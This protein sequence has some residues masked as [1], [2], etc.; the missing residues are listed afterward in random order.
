MKATRMMLVLLALVMVLGMLP[1]SAFATEE[2][3]AAVTAEKAVQTESAVT[4]GTVT[5]WQSYAGSTWLTYGDRCM[6]VTSQ[7]NPGTVFYADRKFENYEMELEM[8]LNSGP[9]FGVM[10]RAIGDEKGFFLVRPG[11]SG[12]HSLSHHITKDGNGWQSD[13]VS[14]EAGYPAYTTGTVMN[15][16]VRVENNQVSVWTKMTEDADYY[17]EFNNVAVPENL[18]GAGYVGIC[19]QYSDV[20][21]YSASIQDLDSDYTYTSDFA[22]VRNYDGKWG[23]NRGTGTPT[24]ENGILKPNIT[25]YQTL[26][27]Y[28]DVD[29]KNYVLETELAYFGNYAGVVFRGTNSNYAYYQLSGQGTANRSVKWFKNDSA[30]TV[31]TL[32]DGLEGSQ[33]NYGDRIRIRITINDNLLTVEEKVIGKD[34]DW[35]KTV[36]AYSLTEN[37]PELGIAGMIGLYSRTGADLTVYDLKI[38]DADTGYCYKAVEPVGQWVFESG[39]GS[40]V[41]ENGTIKPGIGSFSTFYKYSNINWENYVLETEFSYDAQYAGLVFRGYGDYNGYYNIT[42]ADTST[43]RTVNYWTLSS[44]AGTTLE[45]V[46]A[47]GSAYTYGAKIKL[48]V[49]VN[50]SILTIEE[51][52]DGVDTDWVKTVDGYSLTENAAHLGTAGSIGFYTRKGSNLTIYNLKVT[53]TDTGYCYKA[54]DP[55]GTWEVRRGEANITEQDG[56]MS[57]TATKNP[58]VYIYSNAMWDNYMLEA[59]YSVSAYYGA[60]ILRTNGTYNMMHRFGSGSYEYRGLYGYNSSGNAWNDTANRVPA[61]EGYTPYTYGDR[62]KVRYTVQNNLLTVQTLIVG[63]DTEWFTELEN[64]D[65]STYDNGALTGSGEIGFLTRTGATVNVYSFKITDTD[66]GFTYDML[67]EETVINT[68]SVTF[69]GNHVIDTSAPLTQTPDTMEIWFK[70]DAKVEQAL[71]S[72]AWNGYQPNEMYLTISDAG[73]LS[74]HEDNPDSKMGTNV[75]FRVHSAAG[76]NDGKWHKAVIRRYYDAASGL[77]KVDLSVFT[78]DK[79]VARSG[80][81]NVIGDTKLEQ[82]TEN[83]NR[84]VSNRIM[85]IGTKNDNRYVFTG[86]IGEI[87]MWDSALPDEQIASGR[88]A[89]DGTETGLLHCFIPENGTN[90]VDLVTSRT[91]NEVTADMAELWMQNYVIGDADWRIAVLPDIQH[92]TE[93]YE[94]QLRKYFAWI[95]D[96]AEK[97]NIKLVMSVGDMVNTCTPEQMH[98]VSEASSV[99]DGKVPFMPL[100]GNHDYPNYDRDFMLWNEYFPYAKYSQYDYFGGAFEEGR[101]DNYYYLINIHGED[102]LFMGLELCVRPVVAQWA[103]E[104][105]A[106]HPDHK[107][108]I[109][110]HDYLSVDSEIVPGGRS[111]SNGRFKN[112][113]MEATELYDCLISQHDNILLVISGHVH[114]YLTGRRTDVTESGHIVNSLG[115]DTAQIERWY[116]TAGMVDFLGFTDGSNTVQVNS[117]STERGQFFKSTDQFTI[118]LDWDKAYPGYT[119]PETV[120]DDT[121]AQKVAAAKSALYGGNANAYVAIAGSAT[122]IVTDKTYAAGAKLNVFGQSVSAW[123]AEGGNVY[124]HILA[125]GAAETVTLKGETNV[126][127]QTGAFASGELEVITPADI[128]NSRY[129]YL[130]HNWNATVSGAEQIG[131]TSTKAVGE[132]TVIY[133]NGEYRM[134]AVSESL[135]RNVALID[136]AGE[137]LRCDIALIEGD[138]FSS[139]TL[140]ITCQKEITVDGDLSDWNENILSTGRTMTG[141]GSTTHKNVTVYAYMADDGLYVAAVANHEKY[142]DN[143]D[144]WYDNTNLEFYLNG[145]SARYWLTANPACAHEDVQDAFKTQVNG[146]VYTTVAEGF[147][148]M[149]DLPVNAAGGEIKIGFAWKTP[150]DN[151]KYYNMTDGYDWW[152]LTR[153]HPSKI[154]EQYYVNASGVG[155]YSY[156]RDSDSVALDGDFS[157]FSAGAQENKLSIESQDG[158]VGFDVVAQYIPGYGVYVGVSAQSKTNPRPDATDT[159]HH[160]TNLEFY[161]GENR[162]YI[163][164]RGAAAGNGLYAKNVYWDQTY[165]ETAGL[166]YTTMEFFIPASSLGTVNNEDYLRMGFAFKPTGESVLLNGH[167]EATDYWHMYG[168]GPSDTANQFYVYKNGIH[169]QEQPDYVPYVAMVNG[170]GYDTVQ[171]A[172]DNANGGVVKLYANSDEEVV[173]LGDLYLDLNGYSLKKVIVSGTLYGMD[174]ATDD[175]VSSGA[176]IETVEGTYAAHY[177]NDDAKRYLAI[178]EGDGVSFHRFYMGITKVS[179]K[180]EAIGFG[181]KAEFYGDEAVQAQIESIGYTLWMTEGVEITRS[182]NSFKSTLTLRLKNYDVVNYGQTAVNAKVFVTLTDGT[183]I[184]SLAT[185]YSMRQMLEVIAQQFASYTTAQKK[186]VQAMCLAQETTHSWDIAPILNWTETVSLTTNYFTETTGGVYTLTTDS[187]AQHLVDDVM[188]DGVVA[189]YAN[190]SL[191]GT[192]S[193]TD[194]ESW[195]QARILVSADAQNEYFIALEKTD[196]G[197]YQIFT[198]SKANEESWNNWQLIDDVEQNGSRNSIDFEV[199][200]IGDALYFLIEDEVY[201]TSNSVSMTESTV[202]FTGYNVGTTTVEN[203]AL[204]VFED[205]AAAQ[206]YADSKLNRYGETFGVSNGTYWTTNG[207]DTTNDRGESPVLAITGG[208]P[209]YAYVNGVYGDQFTMET[210]INVQAVLNNDGYPKFGLLVNGESEMVKFFVDMTPGMTAT[211][212]GVVYQPTGGSDDWTNSKSVEVAGMSFAG[213]DTIKLKLVRDGQS[214]QFYVNDVLVLSDDAGFQAENGTVGIFSFN[215]VLTASNYT[216]LVGDDASVETTA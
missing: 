68:D 101:M 82:Y 114:H 160:N 7:T 196:A 153:R 173:A 216:V 26:Y 72:T 209:Q 4:D 122:S 69:D 143:A 5:G 142:V 121:M 144:I 64:Y 211:H 38:T 41:I 132:N 23:F 25:S 80:Q 36:D 88:I 170:T 148:A 145:D 126:I 125:L 22:P 8:Q 54:I 78:D 20:T 161:I 84:F 108:F 77:L 74:Y 105:I 32:L 62:V 44:D 107:V 151:I 188:L 141:I 57:I 204:E 53:D 137:N 65:M 116:G 67:P 100:M 63:K 131:F 14:A 106:A 59:E 208:A 37:A 183:K 154:L 203:L 28:Q 172:V 176:K 177:R 45:D 207:V 195:G 187:D 200:A 147:I 182:T 52:I 29:W 89:L 124:V 115:F 104:V 76:F 83:G 86:E 91:E 46:S 215:T 112:D 150:G 178:A 60:I 205:E 111:D 94:I 133:Y 167:T 155:L 117:Y 184:E 194:A 10:Y 113:G 35:I 50:D 168:H 99:L 129:D 198:M 17:Q 190:Y 103:N 66:T 156:V 210:Q 87:R 157:D 102:Y 166:Y 48:R 18:Q 71:L 163:T 109:V 27:I 192:I 191:K 98:I 169:L 90:L 158:T 140:N 128:N 97:Y 49:T 85:Q 9:W 81:T 73:K 201:Y 189:K 134:A 127:V 19:M 34:A 138:T 186:A 199:I 79:L 55:S 214:Y 149:E 185:S 42:S 30:A 135:G 136:V 75:D 70:T 164:N 212:V 12:E 95:R 40:P 16:K 13:S 93:A 3:K 21:V 162:Y 159:W 130:L 123:Y 6:K 181:Y 11:A 58:T 171:E 165:D 175:Y 43:K 202:K 31:N 152:Y 213:S 180:P 51:K 39:S 47:K 139:S 110:T 61:K 179:L 174:S 15:V 33:Y 1:V 118:E 96:N 197:N 206:T 119:A 120:T 56:V 146:N 92:N 193:L 24:V 2:A